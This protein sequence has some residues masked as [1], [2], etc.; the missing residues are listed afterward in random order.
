MPSENVYD[1]IRI[2]N[3]RALPIPFDTESIDKMQF[4]QAQYTYTF[5]FE[6]YLKS[7]L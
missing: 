6:K 3:L 5:L 2:K 7:F 1:C 4:I